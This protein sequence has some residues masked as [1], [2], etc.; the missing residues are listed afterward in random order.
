MSRRT[1][2]RRTR[3]SGR[4]AIY[5]VAVVVAI[6]LATLGVVVLTR[7]DDDSSPTA[8]SDD[9]G[10]AHVHGLGV[11]PA[12]GSIFVATHYGTFR[13]GGDDEPAERVGDS[14]QDT[15]GF[16]VAGPDHFLGS[17]HPDVAGTREGLPGLLG[18]IESTDAGA[19]WEPVSL[20]GEVDFHGLAYAHDQV[21]G[22]DST[23]SR[24][25]VSADQITWDERSTLDLFGFAVDPED[26]NHFIGTGPD[27]LV[28]T[29]DGG[30]TWARTGG[31]G[32]VVLSWDADAG[33]WGVDQAG[34]VW[35]RDAGDW[36]QAG[37]L[38]GG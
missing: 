9:P 1:P 36:T 15:M 24:F 21:Y 6:T 17:G 4:T 11:N 19:T 16:T 12:D 3:R 2:T 29:T 25:L 8:G 31:P 34:A 37:E 14:F 33:L 30:R 22:W 23:S 38:P 26:A 18:L 10:V 28:E 27:G 7:N 35:Q 5:A 32:L 20:L 13:L